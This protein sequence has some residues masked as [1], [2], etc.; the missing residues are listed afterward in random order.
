MDRRNFYYLQNV[1]EGEL[2]AAFDAVEDAEEHMGYEGGGY[3]IIAGLAVS[4]AGGLNVTIAAG[5]ARVF[6]DGP[7]FDKRCPRALNVGTT[8]SL[9]TDSNGA[10]LLVDPGYERWVRISIAEDYLESDP[11][12]DGN[13][14]GL[15][16][17][18]TERCKFYV[19]S[20]AVAASSTG[21]Q[22]DLSVAWDVPFPFGSSVVRVADVKL[23]NSGAGTVVDTIS[24]ELR[25]DWG[26]DVPATVATASLPS[27]SMLWQTERTGT[28][29]RLYARGIAGGVPN[30]TGLVLTQN[31]WW[32]PRTNVWRRDHDT[33]DATAFYF[34]TYLG[35]MRHP[36]ADGGGAASWEDFS[37]GAHYN[38][39]GPWGGI[40]ALKE[41]N[42]CF[43]TDDNGATTCYSP[44]G[45]TMYAFGVAF[46]SGLTVGQ[47]GLAIG[48]VVFDPPLQ[49]APS[50]VTVGAAIGTDQ[51]FP[52]GTPTVGIDNIHDHGCELDASTATCANTYIRC[53]RGVVVHI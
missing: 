28:R 37:W 26:R 10:S 48:T 22:Y 49:A 11:R 42:K 7:P 8:I 53:A 6:H 33:L 5:A 32:D 27:Y 34:S 4:A 39:G 12:T 1:T 45:T 18:K 47:P 24:Y 21:A 36:S 31:A 51:G 52:A 14:A 41:G 50:S 15:Y 2:N 16:F 13:G 30:G 9:A 19:T 29:M 38:I 23:K 20:G 43:I 25:Q 3:G 40:Y 44:A 35:F 46:A 17:V